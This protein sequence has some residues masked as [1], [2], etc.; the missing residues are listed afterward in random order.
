MEWIH[1]GRY[2]HQRTGGTPTQYITGTQEFYGRPFKVSPQVLIPRPETEHVVEVALTLEPREYV[3]DVGCGSGAIAITLALESPAHIIATDVSM[4]AL[5]VAK[6]NAR[7][8]GAG[9]DFVAADL[10][11]AVAGRSIDLLVSN[12]PY[13]PAGD[14]DGLQREVRDHEPHVALIGGPSGNEVYERLVSEAARVLRPGGHLIFELG[15][16]SA[17]RLRELLR[18]WKDVRFTGDLAG[19]PRVVSART[20]D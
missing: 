18:D 12:P 9:V 8:L 7:T 5:E 16:R 4:A 17:D 19:I 20:R 2:L 6:E 15:Y 11:S 13:V 1:Y 14:I 10:L 3:V